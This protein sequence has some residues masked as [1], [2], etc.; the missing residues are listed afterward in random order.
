MANV[1]ALPPPNEV[2]PMRAKPSRTASQVRS[3]RWPSI[4]HAPAGLELPAAVRR[5]HVDLDAVRVEEL[6]EP[7]WPLLLVLAVDLDAELLEC[8]DNGRRGLDLHTDV[9]RAEGALRPRR[10][11]HAR[12][13][14]PQQGEV[15][16]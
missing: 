6:E 11:L 16:L 14:R 15:H 3:F 8:L 5:R 1:V 4:R 13:V 7:R 10:R 9:V 2:A 12:V